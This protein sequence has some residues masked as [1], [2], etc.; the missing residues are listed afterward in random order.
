MDLTSHPFS[1]SI[2]MAMASLNVPTLNVQG[3]NS[4]AKGT[5]AFRSL[6]STKA[7]LVC[8]Q[9]THRTTWT[10]PKFFCKSFPQVYTASAST[11]R[12]GVLI[13]FQRSTPFTLLVEGDSEDHYLIL[14][15]SEVTVVS[16]YAPNKNSTLFFYHLLTVMD[17]HK[18]ETLLVCEDSNQVLYP[19]SNKSLIPLSPGITKLTFQLLHCHS[20]L[21]FWC[22]HKHQYTHYSYPQKLFSLI[23]HI[24][25]TVGSSPLILSSTIL[26]ISQSDPNAVIITLS[27]LVPKPHNP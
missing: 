22:E 1:E 21:D 7:H 25:V 23:D 8:L 18:R 27:S 4:P 3:L 5:K 19:F 16:Y 2:S 26:P 11:K 10:I 15:D 20:L 17:S 6:A 9:E 12:R 24:L 13:A 14:L